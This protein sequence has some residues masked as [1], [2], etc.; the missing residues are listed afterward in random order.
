MSYIE[1]GAAAQFFGGQ[2]S[3]P[4][5]VDPFTVLAQLPPAQLE[6]IRQDADTQ[7]ASLP[8]S[9]I[10]QSD[11]SYLSAEYKTI[12]INV[13]QMQIGYM[14]R[15][16]GFMLLLTLASVACSIAVGFLAARVAAGFGRDTRRKIFTK[17]ENYSNSEFDKFSTASLITRSTNDIP[18]DTTGTG[19]A[20]PDRVLCAHHGHRRHN[21]SPGPGCLDV[22]D[23][24][25]RGHGAAG[26]DRRGIR[27]RHTQVQD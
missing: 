4:P 9:V 24:R 23:Y 8:E 5:G 15:I 14:V 1:S 27:D 12:G 17:V 18:A 3:L 16:G 10:T 19:D 6:A 11:V 13:N 21:Q 20:A 26:D 22:L 7:L 25:G 2:Q